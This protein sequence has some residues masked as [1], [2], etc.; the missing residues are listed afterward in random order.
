MTIIGWAILGAIGAY[1]EY[2]RYP[3]S[4]TAP[5]FYGEDGKVYLVNILNDGPLVALFSLF[6]GYLITI[7][8]LIVEV[9][10]ALNTLFGHGL[11]TLPKA[12][13]VVSYLIFGLACA[14]PWLLFRHKLGNLWTVVLVVFLW[15][16]PLGGW[17]YTTLG[18]VGNL[19]FLLFYVAF[20]FIMY[21]NSIAG[22]NRS[23]A[24]VYIVD[25][26]LL[27]CVT[28]NIVIV[29][30]LPLA[31]FPYRQ[32]LLAI[33]KHRALKSFVKPTLVSLIALGLFCVVY[34][35][36]L[37]KIGIPKIPGYL[38]EK[39]DLLGLMNTVY[40]SSW[41]AF[42][43]PLQQSMNFVFVGMLLLFTSVILI[44][45]KYRF[46]SFAVLYAVL[47]CALGFA[48]NR[49]GVTHYFVTYPMD[50]GPG[51]FFYG[52]TMIFM[53]GVA[54]VTADWFKS[55]PSNARIVT[56]VLIGLYFILALPFSGYRERSY[57]TYNSIPS[58]KPALDQACSKPGDVVRVPIY[59][60]PEW[61]MD[62]ARK[63]AC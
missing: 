38:D 17:A 28:T 48:L 41:Y 43:Y 10:M 16:V 44:M 39:L 7:Q 51:Q 62:I 50:G 63:D 35:I 34:I 29:A 3:F 6:N 42:L 59:P 30:L 54:Y 46:I 22:G 61:Y 45:K 25:F 11:V 57:S 2:K 56:L 14:L 37:Y 31:L 32:D 23:S 47:V 5:N 60:T 24:R 20:I 40:R 55:L 53:F 33:W 36:V 9:A 49:T 12:I 26:I 1:I 27:L 52:G 21:R 8:Y 4:Y 15:F 58:I 19:K 18:T 13:A